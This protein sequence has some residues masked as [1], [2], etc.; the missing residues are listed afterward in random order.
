MRASSRS[1]AGRA[2]STRNRSA[3]SACRARAAAPRRG[4]ARLHEVHLDRRHV[5]P[6]VAAQRDAERGDRV[7]VR[8]ARPA[9]P[10]SSRWRSTTA[11]S[12]TACCTSQ[13][14][15]SSGMYLQNVSSALL[16]GRCASACV[17]VHTAVVALRSRGR[18]SSASAGSSI[19]SAIRRIRPDRC[20]MRHARV[21]HRE[22]G[23]ARC[24]T[25]RAA[26]VRA[27]SP[28]ARCARPRL[29]RRRRKGLSRPTAMLGAPQ[30][31]R[32]ASSLPLAATT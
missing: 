21:R 23:D 8:A 1:W 30:V 31:P 29:R 12:S 2:R 16:H 3:A 28:A 22:I 18:R 4:R 11:S 17:F 7:L 6:A 27:R 14:S 9:T 13:P 15:C 20:A 26:R 25:E 24:R 32:A 10:G 5:A 19:S